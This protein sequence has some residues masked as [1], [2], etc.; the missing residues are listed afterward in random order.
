M[1]SST[2]IGVATLVAWVTSLYL[3]FPLPSQRIASWTK[4]PQA[5]ERVLEEE[6]ARTGMSLSDV[7]RASR[8]QA[9]REREAVWVKWFA[10][11]IIVVGGIAAGICALRSLQGWRSASAATSLLYLLGWI[12]I[13][14]GIHVPEHQTLFDTYA[15]SFSNH[16]SSGLASTLAFVQKD[17][18]SPIV[19]FIV[20]VFLL[21]EH[22]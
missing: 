4:D 17:I 2:V 11:T 5:A 14:S 18:L 16:L 15:S 21:Y 8:L 9:E 10:M 6:A 7:K 22:K 19:H 3:L 1:R 12:A 13:L 20:V